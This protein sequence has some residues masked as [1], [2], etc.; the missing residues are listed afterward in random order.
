MPN[1]FLLGITPGS[2]ILQW[3]SALRKK[4]K[5]ISLSLNTWLYLSLQPHFI[6]RSP[7][8]LFSC[9]TGLLTS[10]LICHVPIATGL[11]HMLLLHL[12]CS[13]PP[14]LLSYLLLIQRSSYIILL[15]KVSS[16]I[17]HILIIALILH[18]FMCLIIKTFPTRL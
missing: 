17:S 6:P 7:F 14:S 3:S 1:F 16:G 13:F 10:A 18:L 12:E 8:P 4:T 11:L 15:D 9:Y 5:T 2:K